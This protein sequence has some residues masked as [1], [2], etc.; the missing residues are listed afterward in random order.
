MGHQVQASKH[1]HELLREQYDEEVEAKN[2][3]MR[4]LSK[5][6]GEVGQWKTKYET[7]AIQRTEELEEAKK[8]LSGRLSEAEESVEAA[9]AKCSSLEKSK[10]RLQGE[11][12]DLTVEL[13]RANAAAANLEKKQKS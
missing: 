9:L 4:Q 8:K 12:E 5:S 6:N 1:D 11:I 10:G 3:L 7:D 13:E 2:E